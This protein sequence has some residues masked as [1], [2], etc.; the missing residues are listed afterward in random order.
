MTDKVWTRESLTEQILKDTA[1]LWKHIEA[2]Q[3]FPIGGRELLASVKGGCVALLQDDAFDTK[4]L[5]T[6][7]V[8]IL[9]AIRELTLEA[10]GKR[11][12]S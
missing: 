5:L 1:G 12:R 8:C 4:D 10:E 3:R 11:G 2:E 6:L 7:A 9:H